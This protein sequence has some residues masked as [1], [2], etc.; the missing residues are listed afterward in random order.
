MFRT[1]SFVT[2]KAML[3]FLNRIDPHEWSFAILGETFVLVWRE[4]DE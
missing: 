4:A 3:T 2:L 1:S